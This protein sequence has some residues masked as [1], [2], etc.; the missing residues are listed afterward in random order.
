MVNCVHPTHFDHVLEPGAAWTSR[1][2][3]MRA[4]ASTM[5]H[6]E[7]DEATELETGWLP[8]TPVGDNLLH[9]AVANAVER[10]QVVAASVGGRVDLDDEAVLVGTGEADVFANPVILRRPLTEGARPRLVGRMREF[11]GDTPALLMSPWPTPDLRGDGLHLYGH[12]PFMVRPPAAADPGPVDGLEI[13]E[14]TDPDT[15][16]EVERTLIDGFPIEV[17]DAPGAAVLGPDLLGGRFRQFVGRVG[18]RPVATAAAMVSHGVVS[19]ENVATLPGDRGRGYGE[20]LTWA[21]TMTD[22]E[23]PA[24]LI[25]SDPGRPV[26]ERMGFLALHR[27]TLWGWGVAPSSS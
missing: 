7:L 14:A 12:P 1:L 3:G 20:A 4:N 15:L 26:Y 22:P 24:V 27:W 17:P 21:A 9:S 18:G 8:T 13:V 16:V 25:A 2:R 10:V 11:L 19:V 5:S 6:A 23:L